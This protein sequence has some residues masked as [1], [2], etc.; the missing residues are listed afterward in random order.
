VKRHLLAWGCVLLAAALFDGCLSSHS[1]SMYSFVIV[2]RTREPLGERPHRIGPHRRPVSRR[3]ARCQGLPKWSFSNLPE[4]M[5][6]WWR[7]GSATNVQHIAVSQQ[8]PHPRS[9]K[10]YNQLRLRR[11]GHA[12]PMIGICSGL[13]FNR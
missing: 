5:T 11:Q 2:N 10:V 12:V 8:L 3:S 7:S 1:E 9:G 4:Q 13:G 6:V